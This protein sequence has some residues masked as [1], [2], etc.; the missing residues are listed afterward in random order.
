MKELV[1][2]VNRVKGITEHCK[3]I[4]N[5]K[6]FYKDGLSVNIKVGIDTGSWLKD[7]VNARVQKMSSSSQEYSIVIFGGLVKFLFEKSKDVADNASS[8]GFE[9]ILQDD[10]KYA[11]QHFVFDIWVYLVIFH[12][13]GHII[14]GHLQYVKASEWLEFDENRFSN[15]K[16]LSSEYH[17]AMELE[18]DMWSGKLCISY[19]AEYYKNI[20]VCLS[21]DEN[22][23]KIWD[24][25]FLMIIILMHSFE[26][27][28]NATH[29]P[30]LSRMMTMLMFI[31]DEINAKPELQKMLPNISHLTPDYITNNIVN[32]L[33][34]DVRNIFKDFSKDLEIVLSAKSNIEK[35]G[36]GKFRLTKESF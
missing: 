20:G 27:N 15:N 6:D 25:F 3:N 29:P 1:D 22:D 2:A 36:L 26:N 12:E 11:F 10:Q 21:R 7:S 24:D 30:S 8:F 5:N 35:I 31:H 32:Y 33:K 9:N 14:S 28:T 34:K 13:Y 4:F 17:Y 18:A 23:S 19:L 16:S